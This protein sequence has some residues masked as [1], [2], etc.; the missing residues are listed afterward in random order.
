VLSIGARDAVRPRVAQAVVAAALSALAWL[1]APAHASADT[2]TATMTD[3]VDANAT[4]DIAQ[5]NVQTNRDA[6][7]LTLSVRLHAPV[8]A[9][10]DFSGG[11]H[12]LVVWVNDAPAGQ[13]LTGGG[14]SGKVGDAYI[15]IEPRLFDASNL[16][17]TT[18]IKFRQE[19]PQLPVTVSPDRTQLSLTLTDELLKQSNHRCLAAAG[20]G[21]AA[22][23]PTQPGGGATYDSVADVWFD[24]QAPP[25]GTMPPVST[26]WTP[27]PSGANP[28]GTPDAATGCQRPLLRLTGATRLA[29][30]TTGPVSVRMKDDFETEYKGEAVLMMALAGNGKVF[31]THPFTRADARALRAG[32][33]VEFFIDLDPKRKP[34]TV[35]L[36][37]KQVTYGEE[38]VDCSARLDVASVRGS[39]PRFGMRSGGTGELMPRGRRCWEVRGEKVTVTVRGG[40]RTARFTRRDAC[41]RFSGRARRV[42][43]LRVRQTP[44]GTLEFESYGSGSA[45]LTV[46]V[47]RRVA[48]RRTVVAS[49]RSTPD[50]RIFE[51]TD[52]FFNYCI[53]G[54]KELFSYQLRL[55]CIKPGSYR[56]A[57]R[58]RR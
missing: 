35:T 2:R 25:P 56:E 19:Y 17:A 15:S 4:F 9:A 22:Y 36:T 24:G 40:G 38:L 21:R 51:G 31:Y 26:P 41:L 33:P 6:G 20:S 29:H 34:A 45:A 32:D 48:L 57:V 16:Q 14:V 3:G 27:T 5:V 43:A 46:K 10:P 44:W 52:A 13:C 50:R 49:V 47:G 42:G 8:P 18:N 12:Y 37:W 23:D 55:Y 54:G 1:A 7:I 28:A 53:N 58:F 39:R 11:P 30:A